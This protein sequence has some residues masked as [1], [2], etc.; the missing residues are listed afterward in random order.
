MD[1]S[2]IRNQIDDIDSEIIRLLAKR[3][4]LVS[5]AG[6]LKKSE[7]EVSASDRVKAVI[8]KVRTKAESEGLDP[9]VA[10]KI[11]RTIIDCFINKEMREFRGK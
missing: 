11:Y 8:N 3:S 7:A 5:E 4:L 1:L 10:E 2:E 9:L 6:K